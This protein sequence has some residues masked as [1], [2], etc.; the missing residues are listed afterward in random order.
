[1]L[2]ATTIKD[3]KALQPGGRPTSHQSFQALNTRPKMH[4]HTN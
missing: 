3:G 2:T 1:M 4:Q